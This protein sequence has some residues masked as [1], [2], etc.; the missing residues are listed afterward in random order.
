MNDQKPENGLDDRPD[1]AYEQRDINF[2]AIIGFGV[3]LGLAALAV[4][5]GLYFLFM[6][7]E[8]RE[9]QIKPGPLWYGQQIQE[10]AQQPRLE[11]LVPN[12]EVARIVKPKALR[13]ESYG[14]V[15]QKA[16]I[17]HIP[18]EQAINL[19]ATD[20]KMKLPSRK[21]E[22]GQEQRPRGWEIPSASSSGR[23][24]EEVR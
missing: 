2:W 6:H 23:Q 19:L 1:V 7:Y 20:E 18:I 17:A 16:G 11:G 15:D 3:V 4:H 9:A 12:T 10:L 13:L 8:R 22:K 24:L 21:A 5:V 14:W